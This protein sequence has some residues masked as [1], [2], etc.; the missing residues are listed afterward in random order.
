[1]LLELLVVLQVVVL[2]VLIVA[3]CL[4][5]RLGKRGGPAS[6]DAAESDRLRHEHR[7]G[8]KDADMVRTCRCGDRYL[9]GMR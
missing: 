1:M 9:D 5:W 4:L 8:P 2:A 3:G 7:F 6:V